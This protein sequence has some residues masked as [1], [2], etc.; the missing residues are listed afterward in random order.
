MK[1][2]SNTQ[3]DRMKVVVRHLPPTIN[4]ATLMEQIDIVF[5]GRYSW[6]SFHQGKNSQRQQ[7][8]SR[9][10]I[11]FK[12]PEDVIEFAEFFNGH[13]FVNEKG[14]QFKTI[15]EYAPSQRVPKQW[16]KKDIREGTIHKDLDYIEFLELLAKPV[17]NLP[18]AEIQL[19]RREAE[20][21]G[22]AKEPPIV[23]PLMD[24][25]RQKR[26]AKSVSRRS[27]PNG[28]INRRGGG[29]PSGSPSSASSKR[30]S[31]KRRNS[32]TMQYVLRDPSKSG[33]KDKPTRILVAKRD[34][35]PLVGAGSEVSEGNSSTAGV[36]G[37]TDAGKKILLLKGKEKEIPNISNSMSQRQSAT[38]TRNTVGSPLKQ[39]QRHENSGKIIRS[40]LLNKDSRQSQSSG[41]VQSEQQNQTGNSDKDK[42]PPR[43]SHAQ[44]AMKDTNGTPR[45][46]DRPDRGLWTIRRSDGAY[47]SAESFSSSGSQPL[48][49]QFDISEGSQRDAKVDLSYPRSGDV[50]TP[51][52]GR[53]NHGPLENGSYKHVARRGQSHI[54]K[55][56]DSSSLVNEGKIS[57]RSGASSHVTN[58][59]QVWVQKTNS[60]P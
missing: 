34:D 15:V 55:D 7:L 51:A 60:G 9:A 25:I 40:I 53:S 22:A 21:A 5:A 46:K 8:Y 39:N 31:E 59:K 36:S 6:F 4:E 20:R 2:S 3:L 37:I 58:E 11:D 43:A 26:A 49:S 14:T 54:A 52:T 13:V 23:T 18:S 32:T 42:R 45:N 30:V 56:N 47:G 50:R 35:I 48:H 38:V 33:S 17:E 41:G 24:F 19:E 57:K 44:I 28:K 10:Y 12:K 29:S 1:N 16:S 27:L